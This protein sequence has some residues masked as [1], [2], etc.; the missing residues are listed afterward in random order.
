MFYLQNDYIATGWDLSPG[1]ERNPLEM[2]VAITEGEGFSPGWK[3][4]PVSETEPAFLARANSLEKSAKSPCIGNGMSARAGK[5]TWAYAMRLFI[6]QPCWNLS[7]NGNNNS[8]C[9]TGLKFA[10][11]SPPWY[12]SPLQVD[13]LFNATKCN[14]NKELNIYVLGFRCS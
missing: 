13:T 5:V 11:L 7:W 9:P 12:C 4:I 6:F 1:S 10:I 3:S 8:A 14:I 2:K